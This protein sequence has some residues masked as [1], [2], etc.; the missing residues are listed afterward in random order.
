MHYTIIPIKTLANSKKR[1]ESFVTPASRRQLVLALLKDVLTAA[2]NSKLTDGILLVTPDTEIIEIIKKWELPKIE[3]LLE[4]EEQG[5]NQAVQIAIKWCLQKPISS[6]LIIPADLPLLTP[7][8][9]DELLQ[10][11]KSD[12]LRYDSCCIGLGDESR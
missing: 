11:A 12:Y 9:I 1:L 3:Y 4:P 8:N 2:T 7:A 6:I 5:T 10:I